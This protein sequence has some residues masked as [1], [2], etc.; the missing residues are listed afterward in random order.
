M[1]NLIE[2]VGNDGLKPFTLD[3]ATEEKACIV[4]EHSENCAIISYVNRIS[5]KRDGKVVDDEFYCSIFN[6]KK[7]ETL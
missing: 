3:D 4:C 2:E 7:E 1:E 5:L 6:E